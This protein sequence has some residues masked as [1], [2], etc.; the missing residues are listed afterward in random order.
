[1]RKEQRVGACVGWGWGQGNKPQPLQG[2][3]GGGGAPAAECLQNH[4]QVGGLEGGGH[5][6]LA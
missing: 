3:G 4:S 6:R 1:M 5:W 2:W